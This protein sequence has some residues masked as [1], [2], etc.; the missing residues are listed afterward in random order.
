MVEI[1]DGTGGGKKAAVN[2]DH[3]LV[4]RAVTESLIQHASIERGDAYAWDSTE[5]NIDAGD[6]MLFVKNTGTSVLVI[7]RVVFSGSDVVCTWTMRMGN[8]TPDPTGTEVIPTNLNQT[9]SNKPA[10]AVAFSDETAL[11][12]G[13]VIGRV[14]TGIDGHHDHDA[15]GTVLGQDHWIQVNQDTESI[16]GSVIIKGH[17]EKK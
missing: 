2:S 12:D 16:R 11:A 9:F 17:F 4:T 10:M 14:K 13:L 8:G 3:E 7:D 1:E 5:L 6:T 15:T